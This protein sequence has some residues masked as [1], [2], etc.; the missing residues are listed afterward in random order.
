MSR[1]RG[2]LA[3]VVLLV[4]CVSCLN[5]PPTELG[6][7]SEFLPPAE[8]EAH[9]PALSQFGA[10][11]YLAVRP[12]DV[13]EELWTLLRAADAA[14]VAVRPWLQLPEYGVWLNERNISEFRDFARRYLDSAAENNVSIDWLIFDLE[15]GFAY[16]EALRSA[17]AAGDLEALLRLVSAHRDVA[18]FETASR[19]LRE[20]VDGL[21]ARDVRVMVAT[22]P[23]TIDD[24]GDSDA[25]LQDVFDT[26]LANVPW[27]QV[28]VMAYRP[29]FAEL[30][31]LPLSPGYVASYARSARATFGAEAQVAIGNISTPGLLVP[32][33]Y[34]DPVAV[35]LD[36]SAARSAGIDSISVFS[37]DG[38][39]TAD[40]PERWLTAASA[41]TLQRCYVDPVTGLIR[42]VLNWLDRAADEP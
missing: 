33:G 17:A 42:S 24:L 11:L 4:G 35:R 27:D 21:H 18:V 2:L 7:W 25:D 13:N 34:T 38:M 40:G 20:L 30:F 26:P 37:L 1:K 28:S 29:V 8:V 5:E 36:V 15:P 9:V 6:V 41:S 32:P 31:G 12:D 10:E 23:W 14:G 3:L 19:R 39:V 16:A 22:L